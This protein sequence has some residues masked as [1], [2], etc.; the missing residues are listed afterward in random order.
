V[1]IKKDALV[2][3]LTEKYG[4]R[5]HIRNS[6]TMDTYNFGTEDRSVELMV[7]QEGSYP[8]LSLTYFDRSLRYKASNEDNQRKADAKNSLKEDLKK[9]GL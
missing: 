6:S 4:I 3:A 7:S 9:Q 8:M 5:E 1:K 2:Q